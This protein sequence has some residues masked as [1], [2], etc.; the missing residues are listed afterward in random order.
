MSQIPVRARYGACVTAVLVLLAGL[1]LARVSTAARAQAGRAARR[2]SADYGA[3]HRA[4]F[5]IHRNEH[6]QDAGAPGG[7]RRPHRRDSG[8][9]RGQALRHRPAGLRRERR[10][11]QRRDQ[12]GRR[13][14][15]ADADAGERRRQRGHA[16]ATAAAQMAWTSLVR[17]RYKA[18]LEIPDSDVEA[19]MHLHDP[20]RRK[21]GRLRIHLAPHPSGGA[22]RLSRCRL[23]RPQAR[24]R[25]LARPLLRLHRRHSVCPRAPGSRGARSGQQIVGG[26]VARN[27]A[28]FSTRRRSAI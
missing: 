5:E 13:R 11:Q 10:V 15:E 12:Y 23:R 7:D 26:F 27:C 20:E 19:Q 16:Q 25:S 14:A 18:S 2:R 8:N 17:G 24:S 9:T 4:A 21:P 1:A 22:A 28:T 3:R 6:A